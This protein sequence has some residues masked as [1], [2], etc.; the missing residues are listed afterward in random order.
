MTVFR[1]GGLSMTTR[2]RALLSFGW[3]AV[4]VTALLGCVPF[5]VLSLLDKGGG[6]ILYDFHG[7]L[8]NA[9]VAIRHG[10]NPYQPGFLAHQ[11]AIMRAG[12]IAIGETA[13]HVF[14]IPVY[15]AP[16]N[17]AIIPLSLLPLWLAG[18]IYTALSVAA[19]VLALHLLGVRDWRCPAIALLSWPFIHGLFLGALGP[20]LVLGLA[21]SWRWRSRLWPPAIAVA[22]IVVAKIFPWPLGVWL[23]ITRRY[24]ALA[25]AV[26]LAL[27]VTLGAWAVIGWQGLAQYPQMLANL[28]FI[29]ELRAVSLVAVL[30][31]IGFSPGIAS[32]LALSAAAGLLGLAWRLSRRPDGDSVAFSLAILAALTGTPI[33]WDHYLVLLFVPIALYSPR[34]SALWFVPLGAPIFTVLSVVVAPGGPHGSN[35]AA[36]HD[37]WLPVVYL[38]LEAIVAARICFTSSHG[39][40][41]R[42]RRGTRPAGGPRSAAASMDPVA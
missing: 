8:Y 1:A 3:R 18:A 10:H 19:M 5:F 35:L 11:A 41:L 7:G 9:G 36:A 23:L 25:L 29:Q 4:L 20:F 16:A 27:L 26:A 40:E 22:S 24:K 12:G 14:S 30:I 21:V 42:I 38:A 39:R 28:S 34:L 15:P 32:A 31:A 13:R 2:H 17:V 33:V 37:I 6:G